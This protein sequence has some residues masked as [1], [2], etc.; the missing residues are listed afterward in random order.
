MKTIKLISEYYQQT[1]VFSAV[2]IIL[3]IVTIKYFGL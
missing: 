1:L 3:A 2:A